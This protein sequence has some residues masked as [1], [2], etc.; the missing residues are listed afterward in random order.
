VTAGALGTVTVRSQ[1]DP[2]RTWAA[3]LDA[4]TASG[5][6][7]LAAARLAVAAVEL[8]GDAGERA[9]VELSIVAEESAVRVEAVVRGG[10]G[11]PDRLPPGLVDRG[12][13]RLSA[14]GEVEYVLAVTVG[15][16]EPAHAPFHAAVAD[17]SDPMRLLGAAL[18]VI[19]R[20]AAQ[21][22]QQAAQLGR[23]ADQL[24]QQSGQL[25]QQSGQLT[26][27]AGE[28]ATHQ[29]EAAEFHAELDETNRGLLAVYAELEAANQRIADLL[30]MFSH[31]IRQPLGIITC[32]SSL[33]L[34]GWEHIDDAARRGDIARIAAAG[35]GMTELVEE[36]LTL[37]QLDGDGLAIRRAPIQLS[38]A[39]ADAIAGIF[40]STQEA[41]TVAQDGDHWVLADPRHFHQILTNLLSN[42]F[43]YGSPPVEITIEPATEAVDI[44]VRDHGAGVPADFL[45]RLFGRFARADTP[46]SRAKK[47]TGLGLYIVRQLVQANGGSITYRDHPGGGGCFTVRL[48]ATGP[49]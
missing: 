26:R 30:A 28:L 6:G 48:P 47:G 12:P 31:D 1:A 36:I 37:T 19:D 3:I 9:V 8:I 29:A 10:T 43:K 27:Q 46:T 34:D 40:G 20:Q 11:S 24:V 25:T 42:A 5:L 15:P 35:T 18:S 7:R 4:A 16:P 2:V 44:T 14:A 33:L 13:E 32:Y 45:P 41:I 49:A 17:A 21:L 38:T 22:A 23:Q 39:V